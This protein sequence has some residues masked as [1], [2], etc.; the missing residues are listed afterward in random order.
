VKGWI[1]GDTRALIEALI[2]LLA[3]VGAVETARTK[4]TPWSP[5]E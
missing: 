4:V 3:G 2:S 5:D 1:D